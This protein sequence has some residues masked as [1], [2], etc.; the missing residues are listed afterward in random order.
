MVPATTRPRVAQPRSTVA[1]AL[2]AHGEES[3]RG[4]LP[5]SVAETTPEV[6]VGR[7]LGERSRQC[8]NVALRHEFALHSVVDQVGRFPALQPTTG[9][10]AA[11]ASP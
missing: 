2:P 7:E 9:V 4:S 10:P 8:S 1:G 11:I 5:G 6:L 3:S